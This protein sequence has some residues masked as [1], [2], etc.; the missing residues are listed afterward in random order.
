[1]SAGN[2]SFGVDLDARGRFRCTNG[3][4]DPTAGQAYELFMQRYPQH[5]WAGRVDTLLQI[6]RSGADTVLM[7]QIQATQP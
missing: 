6:T 4:N 2:P 3:S 5:P 1:M 7:Q